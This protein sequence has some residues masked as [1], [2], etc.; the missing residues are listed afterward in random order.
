MI[1]CSKATAFS[2]CRT[3]HNPEF[4]VFQ[5]SPFPLLPTANIYQG[6]EPHLFSRVYLEPSTVPCLSSED[7]KPAL[8]EPTVDS[9]V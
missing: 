4:G 9:E 8:K 6:Q 5:V 7:K 3:K 2:P 1:T